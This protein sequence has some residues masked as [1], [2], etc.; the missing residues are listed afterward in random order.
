MLSSEWHSALSYTQE[1]GVKTPPLPPDSWTTAQY[2]SPRLTSGV[3]HSLKREFLGRA[4]SEYIFKCFNV[5]NFIYNALYDEFRTPCY[6]TLG[7]VEY[8]GKPFFRHSRDD[9]RNWVAYG[10]PDRDNVNLHAWITFPSGEM[11]DA[12]IASVIALNEGD[13]G[14]D[15][16]VY[17]FESEA[18]GPFLYHPTIIGMESLKSMRLAV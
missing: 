16:D 13:N 9:L 8:N 14:A 5:H 10:V 4:T 6:L 12:T 18:C 15:G 3:L 1:L 7:W 2:I 17:W 11:L